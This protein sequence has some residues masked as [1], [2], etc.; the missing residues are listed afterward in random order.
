ML[1]IAHDNRD[2]S[3]GVIAISGMLASHGA[4]DFTPQ[5]SG[6]INREPSEVKADG[7]IYCYQSGSY[8]QVSSAPV[9]S[10]RILLQLLSDGSLRAERQNLSC[11][12]SYFFSSPMTY[13]R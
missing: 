10:G 4:I 2:P 13:K 7:Q 8:D 12:S 3:I 11:A 9:I 6:L 1:G 5:H